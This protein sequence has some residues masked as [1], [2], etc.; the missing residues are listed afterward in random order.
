M[1]FHLLIG[2][3]SHNI[4]TDSTFPY[5]SYYHYLHLYFLRSNVRLLPHLQLQATHSLYRHQLKRYHDCA[6]REVR[7]E[8]KYIHITISWN[9]DITR[10]RGIR[11]YRLKPYREIV[12]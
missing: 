10:S 6:I 5:V 1:D 7:I 11:L 2:L 3:L 12:G 9:A 4:R 8:P